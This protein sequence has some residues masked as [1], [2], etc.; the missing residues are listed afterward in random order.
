M[1]NHYE[2][3]NRLPLDL[4]KEIETQKELSVRVKANRSLAYPQT[5]QIQKLL[6]ANQRCS[7]EFHRVMTKLQYVLSCVARTKEEQH[8]PIDK[9]EM[10]AFTDEV[11]K[12]NEL[13][14][15]I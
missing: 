2:C 1:D 4:K 6:T 13:L 15:E 14:V 7:M 12:Q 10:A 5:K 11:E 3:L 8:E 9:S